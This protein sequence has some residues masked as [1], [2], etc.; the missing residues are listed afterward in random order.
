MVKDMHV[1]IS[2]DQRRKLNT[3][4]DDFTPMMQL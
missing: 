3:M 4:L 1:K 2:T